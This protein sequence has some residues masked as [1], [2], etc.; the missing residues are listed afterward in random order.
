MAF[1]GCGQVELS[2]ER[3]ILDA[4][5]KGNIEKKIVNIRVRNVKLFLV[6]GFKCSLSLS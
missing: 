6:L 3:G 5:V 1:T 4:G 2:I